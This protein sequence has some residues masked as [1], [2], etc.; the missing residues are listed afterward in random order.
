MLIDEIARAES[1]T[2]VLRGISDSFRVRINYLGTCENNDY[3]DVFGSIEDLF[4]REV[5]LL[6]DDKTVVRAK[7]FCDNSCEFWKNILLHEKR[8]LGDI[9]F[10]NP[11]IKRT[12]LTVQKYLYNGVELP[13]RQ[14]IFE[15][16]DEK[17]LIEEYFLPEIK[18]FCDD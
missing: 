7:T 2:A 6:L 15:Y 10:N 17:L 5:E 1:L 13:H 18:L 12:S 8:P 4:L 14:G 11:E 16:L 3:S 9:L